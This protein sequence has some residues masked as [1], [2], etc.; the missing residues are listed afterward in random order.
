MK[1]W[2]KSKSTDGK[3]APIPPDFFR[4]KSS[5]PGYASCRG[6]IGLK[7]V[8]HKWEWKGPGL[9][10]FPH[11]KMGFK[12]STGKELQSEYF[13]PIEHAYEAIM[14]M[15]SLHDKITPHLFISELRT[16]QADDLWMSPCY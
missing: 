16:I 5:Y 15:E 8:H 3:T 6:P 13:V 4:S 1:V 7:P 14:A 12:P 10:G 2:I 9:K 11:F